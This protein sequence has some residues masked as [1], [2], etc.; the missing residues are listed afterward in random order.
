LV[1][2]IFLQ[3]TVLRHIEILGSFPDLVLICVLFFGLFKGAGAG[4]EA[5]IIGGALTDIFALDFF[6]INM[7]ILALSGFLAGAINTKVYSQSRST[8]WIVV[9][10]FSVFSMYMHFFLF[11]IFSKGVEFGFSEHFSNSVLISSLYTASLSVPVF[12][13]FISVYGLG[14]SEEFI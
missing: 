2:A 8:Q 14:E 7:F 3:I 11:D 10:A 6:G 4:F 13:Q 12:S 1:V 9:F 5:G